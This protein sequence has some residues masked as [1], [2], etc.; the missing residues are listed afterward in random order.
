ME[1]NVNEKSVE[2]GITLIDLWIIIQKYWLQLITISVIVAIAVGIVTYNVVDRT[3]T[4]STKLIINANSLFDVSSGS[5]QA[6]TAINSKNYG[7][8]LYSSIKDMLTNTSTVTTKVKDLS[9]DDIRNFY[10]KWAS[11]ITDEDYEQNYNT[12]EKSDLRRNVTCTRSN[13]D[14]LIFTISYTSNQSPELAKATVNAISYSLIQ[15][16]DTPK[17]FKENGDVEKYSYP[18]GGMLSPVELAKSATPAHNWKIYPIIAFI[19]TFVLLYVYFLL[20][21]IFDDSVRSKSEIEE[22]T[23]FNVIAYIEDL[24]DKKSKKRS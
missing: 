2:K 18:F 20:I 24:T 7:L 16:A 4:A 8:S 12:F 1:E 19:G 21:S 10:T 17:T 22:I 23:G 5:G 14:S 13:E 3:Y 9:G 11:D 6:S 15:V